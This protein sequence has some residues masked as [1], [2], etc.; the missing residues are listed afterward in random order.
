MNGLFGDLVGAGENIG[1]AVGILPQNTTA[2]PSNQTG[3]GSN[4]AAPNG[5]QVTGGSLPPTPA[6]TGFPTWGWYAVGGAVL[7]LGGAYF[8]ARK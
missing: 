3:S 7:F 5:T 2:Q 1:M 6:K 8:L 4:T